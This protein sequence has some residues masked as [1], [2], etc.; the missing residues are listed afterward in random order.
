MSDSFANLNDLLKNVALNSSSGVSGAAQPKL[1]TFPPNIVPLTEQELQALLYRSQPSSKLS[2]D[3]AS[4][5]H[6]Q[7]L[8]QIPL[9]SI[10]SNVKDLQHQML[11]FEQQQQQQHQSNQFNSQNQPLT[12]MQQLQ[13]LQQLHQLEQL[14][15]LQMLNQHQQQQQQQQQHHSSF[16]NDY[17]HPSHQSYPQNSDNNN[18]NNNRNNNNPNFKSNFHKGTNIDI[19]ES[20][21]S[22]MTSSG[23]N[24]NVESNAPFHENNNNIDIYQYI[25]DKHYMPG[26][27]SLIEDVD[28]QL[29]V[30]LRD[31]KTLIGYLRSIDQYANLLLS[32]TIERIYVGNKYGDIPRGVNIIRGENVVLIGEVDFSLPMKVDMVKIDYN[33]ILELQQS[34]HKKLADIEKNKKKALLNRCLMPQSDSILDDYY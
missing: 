8:S 10:D 18:N 5:S 23:E 1:P 4:S 34:E 12:Q 3:A 31:G 11:K 17:Q 16:L 21:T 24:E 32:N 2:S 20:N 22:N 33:E 15:K 13:K 30:I 27:A 26:T 25:S 28:K 19:S 7:N 14:Q 6:Q 29:M 9:P